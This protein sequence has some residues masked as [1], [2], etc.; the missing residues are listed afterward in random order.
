MKKDYISG[1][2]LEFGENLKIVLKRLKKSLDDIKIIDSLEPFDHI[3]H[4]NTSTGLFLFVAISSLE[5]QQTKNR[6]MCRN[7]VVYL[8]EIENYRLRCFE[9]IINIK[10]KTHPRQ[11][12]AS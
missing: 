8:N 9:E 4:M 11:R 1:G 12:R 2:T 10:G 3:F 5:R 6:K 7:R